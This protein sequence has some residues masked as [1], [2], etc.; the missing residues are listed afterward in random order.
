M[1]EPSQNTKKRSH[2]AKTRQIMSPRQMQK[3]VRND[4]P[5]FLAVVRTSN[6]FVPREE[7]YEEGKRNLLDID[8]RLRPWHDRNLE[9]E[10]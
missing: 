9:E 8:S 1:I 6:H 2:A 4:E 10:N 5:V 3:L 7:E